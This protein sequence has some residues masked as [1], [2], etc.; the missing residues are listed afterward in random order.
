MY[1]NVVVFFLDGTI[2]KIVFLLLRMITI[3][4]LKDII[5]QREK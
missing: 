2:K 4:S 5:A 1:F 3:N